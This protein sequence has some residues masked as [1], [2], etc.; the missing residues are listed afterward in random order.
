ML[1]AKKGSGTMFAEFLDSAKL[2]V[3]RILPDNI[4][5]DVKYYVRLASTGVLMHGETGKGFKVIEHGDATEH[6]TM[7]APLD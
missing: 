1:K 4:S 7:C 5:K 6:Y 3:G 2:P